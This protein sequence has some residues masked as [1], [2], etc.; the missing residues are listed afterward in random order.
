[1]LY[2]FTCERESRTV[3][4]INVVV[5]ANSEQEAKDKCWEYIE[6]EGLEDFDVASDHTFYPE[7]VSITASRLATKND[8]DTR[9]AYIE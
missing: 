3:D 2:N 1:M 9:N 4:K 7:T 5:E 6:G 8:V